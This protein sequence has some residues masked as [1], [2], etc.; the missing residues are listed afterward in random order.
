VEHAGFECRIAIRAPRERVH[1]ELCDP[2]RQLGLQPFLVAVEPRTDGRGFTAVERVPLL[3]PLALRNPIAVE[4]D[5][6]PNAARVVF[7][8]R[9]RGVEVHATF[10][11]DDGPTGTEVRERVVLVLSTW[12]APLR[13]FVLR[14]AVEAQRRLLENLRVRLEAGPAAESTVQN[15]G[16]KRV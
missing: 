12:L 8:A 5:P 9:S 11:L 2:A 13:G 3:G 7:R 14:R 6:G 1:A 4:I 15:P 16:S 10:E